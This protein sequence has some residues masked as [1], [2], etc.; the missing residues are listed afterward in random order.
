MAAST[1]SYHTGPATLADDPR[2]PN[3]VSGTLKYNGCVFSP[4]FETKV[5]GNP[6][7][8]NAKRTVKYIEYTITVDGY[9]TLSDGLDDISSTMATLYRLLT[10]QGGSLVYKGRGLDIVSNGSADVSWGPTPELLEFQP[11]GAGRS[12]KIS[13]K[14]ITRLPPPVTTAVGGSVLGPLG[15]A[16]LASLGIIQL[17][18]ETSVSY[19]DAGYSTVSIK[20]TLEAPPMGRSPTQATRTVETTVDRYRH[21]LEDR[22]LKGIDLGRFHVTRRNFSVSR[23]KQTMEWDFEAEEKP[24]MDL[25]EHCT[26]ARGSY[27]IRP[28]KQ[29]MGTVQWL[30]TLRATYT[31]ARSERR[32]WAYVAFLTLMFTR[33]QQTL[34]VP[35]PFDSTPQARRVGGK[36]VSKKPWII[37]FTIDEGL[38]LDSRTITFSATW[39]LLCS[40]SQLM[41]AGGVWRK[42]EEG[43][44]NQDKNLW[45]QSMIL[46]R[47]GNIMGSKSWL[48]NELDPKLDVIIDLGS[49]GV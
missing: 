29:G 31:V 15:P 46:S 14:V 48:A 16:P 12:A 1:F 25:P 9:V 21:Y 30:C 7:K 5:S 6:V 32:D 44:R 40:F 41:I 43:G 33:M 49:T 2:R 10:A 17:N 45:A 36:V 34:L 4:L 27:N 18:Y 24:Y 11:L 35:N 20:G 26:L 28:L 39:Q 13:W 8:D 3:T 42:V 47:S 38:Y 19:D 22:I 37:S 23:D